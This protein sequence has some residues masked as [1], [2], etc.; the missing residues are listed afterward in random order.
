MPPQPP[1]PTGDGTSPRLTSCESFLKDHAASGLGLGG[2]GRAGSPSSSSFTRFDFARVSSIV[3]D[4]GLCFRPFSADGLAQGLF[5][6]AS[7]AALAEVKAE[8]AAQQSLSA[9]EVLKFAEAHGAVLPADAVAALRGGG[10]GGDATEHLL[11][12]V[13]NLLRSVESRYGAALPALAKATGAVQDLKTLLSSIRGELMQ[14]AT[15]ARTLLAAAEEANPASAFAQQITVSGGGG[16]GVQVKRTDT[17]PPRV[18]SPTRLRRRQLLSDVAG[19]RDVKAWLKASTL[20][21][22]CL[23]S[24]RATSPPPADNNSSPPC[25]PCASMSSIDLSK[26]T[27][28]NAK[29]AGLL[30][31]TAPV[32]RPASA[33]AATCAPAALAHFAAAVDAWDFDVA[34][35][36]HST[37]SA[38]P[39]PSS[40]AAAAA[41]AKPL[42]GSGNDAALSVTQIAAVPRQGAAA[43]AAG[44][45]A[46]EKPPRTLL[47][48]VGVAVFSRYSFWEAFGLTVEG[49]TEFFEELASGYLDNPYHSQEHAADV[50]QTTHA[51]LCLPGSLSGYLTDEEL[52]T[53]LVSAACH[54]Y[55]HPGI[56]NQCLN[57]LEPALSQVCHR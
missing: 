23:L 43:A 3:D 2:R 15:D 51:L 52:F 40:P 55:H 8:E 35:S 7:E 54:D 1:S 28:E 37:F 27:T 32:L 11:R 42:D 33:S 36:A 34:L 44:S 4:T 31:R 53:L 9:E 46:G 50:L 30:P 6:V 24:A 41:A 19:D 25:S 47:A 39:E 18:Q 22:G 56:D 45:A 49:A 17:P 16:S 13:F 12:Y 38:P 20:S 14:S 48:R 26:R 29:G 5:R 21:G 57:S 10:G